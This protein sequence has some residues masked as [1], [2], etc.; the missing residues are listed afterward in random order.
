MNYEETSFFKKDLKKHLKKYR[1]LENDLKLFKENILEKYPGG[2]P[3]KKS[4]VLKK[5]KTYKIIK[6]RI[7]SQSLQNTMLRIIYFY[8][9]Q[10]NK[11]VFIELYCK[12]EQQNQNSDRIQ[13]YIGLHL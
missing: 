7:R 6:H 8:F 1:S 2:I 3:G 9:F 12:S 10:E 13:D 11:I 4:N 5:C